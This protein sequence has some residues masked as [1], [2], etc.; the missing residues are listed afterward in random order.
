MVKLTPEP[1]KHAGCDW[2]RNW[3]H[4]RPVGTKKEA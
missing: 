4:E 2:T 1:Q 3:L